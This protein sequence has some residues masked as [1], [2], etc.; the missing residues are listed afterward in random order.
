M[1]LLKYFKSQKE[2]SNFD[3]LPDGIFTLEQ[4]GKIIDVNDKVLKLYRTNRFG[5]IARK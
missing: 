3:L 2:D 5:K 1:K 4:G